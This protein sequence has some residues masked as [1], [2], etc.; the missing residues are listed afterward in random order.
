VLLLLAAG[1]SPATVAQALG[2]DEATV[3]RHA[4][5]FMDLGLA[6]YLDPTRPG[7]HWG[8]LISRQLGCLSR[9]MSTTL[10]TDVRAIQA[11]PRACG[12]P[13]RA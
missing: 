6:Q 3:Y 11:W 10:C 2:L 13:S 12:I 1:R 9:E 7:G 4:C 8:R 5:A